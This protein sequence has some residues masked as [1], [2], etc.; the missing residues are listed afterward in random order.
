MERA[1]RANAG[2][3][4][5][6]IIKNLNHKEDDVVDEELDVFHDSMNDE[7]EVQLQGQ[8]KNEPEIE[9]ADE[10]E[11][12]VLNEELKTLKMTRKKAELQALI[13]EEKEKLNHVNKNS[14]TCTGEKV[15][16]ILPVL[17]TEKALKIIDY[18][19]KDPLLGGLY[20]TVTMSG[21]VELLVRKGRLL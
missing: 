11:L 5:N 10:L 3:K 12:H 17:K 8:N 20:E 19:W 13:Q 14:T 4:M 9:N 18:I 21:T 2:K 6:D 1:K 7:L 15:D 16:I